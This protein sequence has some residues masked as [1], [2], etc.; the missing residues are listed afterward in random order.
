MSFYILTKYKNMDYVGLGMLITTIGASCSLVLKSLFQS[1]CVHIRCGCL[2]CDREVLKDN[3][4]A[5]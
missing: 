2:E 4:E 5:K 1:R 3:E